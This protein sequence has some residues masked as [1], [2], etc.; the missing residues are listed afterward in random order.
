[1]FWFKCKNR[2]KNSRIATSSITHKLEENEFSLKFGFFF[3]SYTKRAYYY[4]IFYMIMKGIFLI[5][6]YLVIPNHTF[7]R[8]LQNLNQIVTFILATTQK[9]DAREKK[10]WERQRISTPSCNNH[11]RSIRLLEC[12]NGRC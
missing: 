10:Q 5:S 11:E 2:Y 1:M 12:S 6:K 3:Y 7:G 9:S 8:G 4:E